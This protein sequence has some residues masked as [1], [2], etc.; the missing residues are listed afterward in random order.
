MLL[1]V[2]A[3]VLAAAVR[4]KDQPGRGSSTEP[5]HAQGVDDQLPGHAL[6]HRE[7]NHLTAEQ[8]DDDREIDPS[9]LCPEIGDV[10]SPDMI[11]R[12]DAKL[13][14]QQVWRDRKAMRTI[15]RRLELAPATRLKTV[16][17]HQLAHTLLACPNA[18]RQ[19]FTP[20]TRP[21]IG[22]LHLIENR[23]HVNQESHIADPATGLKGADVPG[24]ARSILAIAAG[25]NV[26]RPTLRRYR[27]DF[28]MSLDK[29]VSHRDSLAK[30]A[31]AFFR[32]SRSI[33][34]LA[35]SAFRR[36]ISICSAL[37]AFPATSRNRPA[38]SAFTQLCR[39]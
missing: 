32:M 38:A 20:D 5:G 37:T 31:A 16:G 4:M 14:L 10:A 6:A 22:A 27:P 33:R 19:K 9:F 18:A 17:L 15:G 2:A 21:A 36:A 34:V 25:A 28:S 7:A 24:L 8:V 11:R 29:G 23:L 1:E 26:Q 39:V 30:Y 35:S 13:A 3:G 12:L